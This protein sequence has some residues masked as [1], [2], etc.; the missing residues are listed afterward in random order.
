MALSYNL[1]YQ[2]IISVHPTRRQIFAGK[3]DST[4]WN[5]WQWV[6]NYLIF[7]LPF[8][9]IASMFKQNIAKGTT[10]FLRPIDEYRSKFNLVLF[11]EGREIHMTFMTNPCHNCDKL[12]A[13][14]SL[15]HKGNQPDKARLWLDLGPIKRGNNSILIGVAKYSKSEWQ[16]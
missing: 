2:E 4:F 13:N 5:I 10:E 16:F 15:M 6:I 12:Y 3:T 7:S 14:G 11:G 9:P 1:G 8:L